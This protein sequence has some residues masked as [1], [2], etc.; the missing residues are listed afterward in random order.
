VEN[1]VVSRIAAIQRMVQATCFAS[2]LCLG[3]SPFENLEAPPEK[4]PD[5]FPPTERSLQRAVSLVWRE[6]D[7][8]LGSWYR[9]VSLDG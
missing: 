3:I 2:S 5:P 9:F 1:N 4:C 8:H 7:G 6:Q